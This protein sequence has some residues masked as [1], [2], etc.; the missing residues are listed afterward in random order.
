MNNPQPPK[1][2]PYP[3]YSKEEKEAALLAVIRYVLS[4]PESRLKPEAQKN[5]A[6]NEQLSLGPIE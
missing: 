6:T 1:S 2:K 4:I 3:Q 5:E